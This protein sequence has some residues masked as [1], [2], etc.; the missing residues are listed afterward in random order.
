MIHYPRNEGQ[1]KH[2]HSC[3]ELPYHFGVEQWRVSYETVNKTSQFT[4][5]GSDCW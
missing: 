4:N 5:R 2:G 1:H 3:L